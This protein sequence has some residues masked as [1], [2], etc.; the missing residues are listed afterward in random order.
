[1]KKSN[2]NSGGKFPTETVITQRSVNLDVL[3]DASDIGAETPRMKRSGPSTGAASTLT[4]RAK[5]LDKQQRAGICQA[6]YAEMDARR[7]AMAN[8]EVVAQV[9]GWIKS[10][11][12]DRL[13]NQHGLSQ[14]AVL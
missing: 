13:T 10:T 3:Q 6:A 2:G 12:L 11:W 8:S 1:M 14:A 4:K 5:G 7:G 9:Q